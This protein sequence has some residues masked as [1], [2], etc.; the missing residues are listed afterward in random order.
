[1]VTSVTEINCLLFYP[2]FPNK[3]DLPERDCQ[4]TL[5]SMA[6]LYDTF[7]IWPYRVVSG[8]EQTDLILEVILTVHRRWYVEIKCQLDA[9]VWFFY[10]KIYYLLKMF[11]ATLCP[12]SGARELYRWLLPVVFGSLVYR[13][14]FWCGAVGYV[15]SLRDTARAV[16]R[17]TIPKICKPKSQ[18]PQ[19][20]AIC[21]TLELLMIG[22]MK[23]ETCWASSKFCNKKPICC[24]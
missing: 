6:L 24:I 20:A 13:S 18:I 17:N 12:S 19:V 14:L 16:F 22:I 9:T 3:G 23:P 5:C 4:V 11:R 15:S 7:I 10:C 1:M 21:I 8:F 2:L